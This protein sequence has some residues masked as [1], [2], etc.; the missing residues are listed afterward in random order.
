MLGERALDQL[1]SLRRQVNDAR[2]AVFGIVL[3]LDQGFFL[4]TVDRDANRATGEPDLLTESIHRQ[5][6]FV[7]QNFEHSKVRQPQAERMNVIESM[8]LEGVES[9]PE[10]QPEMRAA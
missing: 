6:T 7:Q 4:Q 9:L 5:R 8:E 1:A 2:A 10:H 3:A